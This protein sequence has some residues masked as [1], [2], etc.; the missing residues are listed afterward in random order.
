MVTDELVAKVDEKIREN[1][2]F[3]ITE[4]SLSFPQVSRTL[5][6]EIVTQKLGYHKFCARWVPKLCVL[7]GHHKGQRMGAALTFQEAYD[8]QGDSLLDRIVTGDETWVRHVNCETKLQSMQMKNWL[9][10]QRFDDNKELQVCVTEWLRSQA[11]EFYDKGISKHV[12]RYDKC[13]N[14]FGDYVEK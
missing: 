14:L 10:V 11:T 5:L 9:A 8:W 7:T 6:F 12:H 2:R 4:L 3:T 13:L 1:R